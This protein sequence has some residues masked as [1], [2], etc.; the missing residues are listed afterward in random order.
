MIQQALKFSPSLF[1]SFILGGF[2]CSTHRRHDG[3]RLDLVKS[4][5]HDRLVVEDYRQ[6]AQ[7]GIYSV[8]DGLRW[9]LIENSPGRYD[10]TSF[11]PMLRAARDNGVQA[12][13]DLCHYGWP[14]DIDI[15]KPEFVERFARF[16]QAA[17]RVVRDET[18]AA[19]FFCPVNQTSY[20]SWAEISGAFIR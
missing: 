17:A 4:T 16:S 7:H 12:I 2:E 5:Q 13:W 1:S 8:R 10:W 6:L 14:S 19:P 11:L 20:F 9:Y 18:D 15:W 3:R